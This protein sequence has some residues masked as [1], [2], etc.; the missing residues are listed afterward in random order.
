[1]RHVFL[2]RRL[3]HVFH[4]KHVFLGVRLVHVF[5]RHVFLGRRLVYVF[6][7]RRFDKISESMTTSE[8][9]SCFVINHGSFFSS[10]ISP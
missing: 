7:C 1:C 9:N 10:V 8:T 4:C 5:H 3:V 6:H 2:G